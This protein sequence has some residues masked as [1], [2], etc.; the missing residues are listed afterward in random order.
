MA[1]KSIL[2]TAL[3]IFSL[4][5][6]FSFGAYA[7]KTDCSKTTDADIVKAIYAAMEAK[8]GDQIIHVNVVVKDGAVTLQGWANK[9]ASKE[10][11]KIVKKTSCVKKDKIVNQLK[12]SADAG[13]A[14]GYKPCGNAC[15][16]VGDPCNVCTVRSCN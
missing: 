5:L 2:K 6:I 8:H 10:I 3:A 1:K 7:Q 4:T 9:K 11:E 15:I 12:P 14:S 16:P 13:C